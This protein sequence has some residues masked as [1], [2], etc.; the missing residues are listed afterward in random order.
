MHRA[1]RRRGAAV[2]IAIGRAGIDRRGACT[3][4]NSRSIRT[5]EARRSSD[6][7]TNRNAP[8]IQRTRTRERHEEA[9]RVRDQGA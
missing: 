1:W 3:G 7:S 4:G 9:A 8:H 5:T 2:A 6:A